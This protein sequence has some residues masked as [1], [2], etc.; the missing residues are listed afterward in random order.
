MPLLNSEKYD[1][2]LEYRMHFQDRVPAVH[3]PYRPSEAFEWITRTRHH[4]CP[5]KSVIQQVVRY[6]CDFVGVAHK[7]SPNRN[8][9]N[10]WR[11]SFSIA[12]IKIIK[13]W[14]GSKE[15]SIDLFGLSTKLFSRESRSLTSKNPSCART[16]SRR[17]C[18]GRASSYRQSSGT[19]HR[20]LRQ[21]VICL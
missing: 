16:T 7:L 12:E 10:E 13:S 19:N 5:S 9:T 4:G 18:C 6:G 20:S 1:T 17:S 2:A 11:F 8:G 3:C 21:C 14:T 15:M